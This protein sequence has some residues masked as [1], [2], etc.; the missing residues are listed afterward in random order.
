MDIHVVANLAHCIIQPE[1]S[2]SLLLQ[3]IFKMHSNIQNTT[4]IKCRPLKVRNHKLRHQKVSAKSK[5]TNN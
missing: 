1:G 4:F 5:D 3:I 2:N